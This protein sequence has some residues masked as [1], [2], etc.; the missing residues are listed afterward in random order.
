[1]NEDTRL[2]DL[3]A[4]LPEWICARIKA[5][6]WYGVSDGLAPVNVPNAVKAV[7]G[8]PEL[9]PVV[10][11]TPKPVFCPKCGSANVYPATV[12]PAER[13]KK[14][15]CRSCSHSWWTYGT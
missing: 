4:E 11:T 14:L 5:A 15:S 8:E 2:K 3:C 13:R 9:A 10:S 12:F 6:Y 7:W 1:M